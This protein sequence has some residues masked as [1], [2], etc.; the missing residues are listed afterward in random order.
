[1]GFARTLAV[2]GYLLTMTRAGKSAGRLAHAIAT[3][4]QISQKSV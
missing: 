2:L 1:M 3:G 4:R